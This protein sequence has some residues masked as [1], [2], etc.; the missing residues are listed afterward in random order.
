MGSVRVILALLGAYLL[1]AVPISNLTARAV[2]GVDLRT[3]GSGTVSGT[4]VYQVAGFGPVAV[5]GVLDIAK[6]SLAVLPMAGSRPVVA[7]LAAGAAV[8]GHNWSVFLRGAG[9]RGISVALGATLVLAPAGTVVLGLGLGIGRLMRRTALAS[10]VAMVLLVPV[11]AI[12]RGGVGVLLGLALV[13]PMWIKRVVG[14]QPLRPPT[15]YGYL[16]RLVFDHDRA[17]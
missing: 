14:N 15:L 2:A 4:G 1:G 8:I 10:F 9:G 13:L 17:Q 7:A 16:H 11:L 12:V 3:F 5:A 6:G